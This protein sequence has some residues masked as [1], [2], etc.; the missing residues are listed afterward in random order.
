M[1][2]RTRVVAAAFR[3][4][5]ALVLVAAVLHLYATVL[6]RDHVLARIADPGLRA[7]VSSGYLL[8]HVLVGIFM[9]PM[10]FLMWW[11]APGLREGR[12]WAL[13]VASSFSLAI[14]TTPFAI[15]LLMVGPE[16]SSPIFSS[17]AAIMA[18]TGVAS[19]AL[20]FWARKDFSPAD[21]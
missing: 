18:L 11:S 5:G 12:R 15:L 21:A 19:C 6:I 2:A 13:V 1:S 10:G 20:L 7:F 3:V 14:L 9:L 17:A 16:Y 4:F 8:N